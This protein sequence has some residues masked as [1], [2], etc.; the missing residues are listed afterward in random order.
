MRKDATALLRAAGIASLKDAA[1]EFAGTWSSVTSVL[2]LE[3]HDCVVSLQLVKA[4]CVMFAWMTYRL[5]LARMRCHVGIGSVRT[6]GLVWWLQLY[7]VMSSLLPTSP[8]FFI[9]ICHCCQVEKGKVAIFTAKC[10]EEGCPLL[11]GDDVFRRFLKPDGL[12]LYDRIML[13]SFIEDCA[14]LVRCPSPHCS[15]VIGVSKWV[16]VTHHCVFCV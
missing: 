10:P 9:M 12:E 13:L 5:L 6:V 7:V 15:H 8:W 1:P 14:N 2:L 16:R 3:F 11:V 4:Q